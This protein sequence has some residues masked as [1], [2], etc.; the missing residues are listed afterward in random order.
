MSSKEQLR[1]Y[2]R[3]LLNQVTDLKNKNEKLLIRDK[4]AIEENEN[5]DAKLTL[6]EGR[7]YFWE[8]WK[9]RY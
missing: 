2:N 6:A 8:F 7:R 9:T 4:A 1:Q 3:R 5:L